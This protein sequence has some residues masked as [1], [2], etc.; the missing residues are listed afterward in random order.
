[1]NATP[2]VIN[3]TTRLSDGPKSSPTRYKVSSVTV[4]SGQ[5]LTL[6]PHA[7]GAERYV[8]IWVTGNLTTL[9]T[10][11]ILQEAGVH[12]T[13]HIEGNVSVLG[14]SFCIKSNVAE[15]NV[16]NLITPPSGMNG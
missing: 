3:R 12:A 13:Y 7:S 9:A 10:G 5:V 2:T 11:C 14:H 8:E 6:A 4:P 16:L 1:M 15:N